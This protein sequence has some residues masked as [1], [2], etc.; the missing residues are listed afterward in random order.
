MAG[1]HATRSATAGGGFAFDNE[2]PRHR[3]YLR[4]F[5]LAGRA[6][7]QRR[8]ARLHRGR[9][10]SPRRA[11]AVRRLGGGA[12]R[13][14]D[15]AALLGARRRRHADDD[16]ARHA[17]A[18][19]RGAGLPRQLLRGRRLR[20]L[21]RQAA[22]DRGGVGGGRRAHLP[23]SRQHARQ[24]RAPATAGA[25]R[26]GDDGARPGRCSA[27]SGNGRPAP[28]SPTPATSRAAGAVGEYNGKFMCNQM[29][30]R[31]GSCVTPDGTCP[32]HLPQL[33]LSAASAGSLPGCAWRRTPDHGR[34]C[35][36]AGRR[37][38]RMRCEEFRA[39]VLAGLAAPQKE[40][41]TKF[42]YDAEGSRLFD[43]I[44]ELD[45]YYPT[46]TE[47]AILSADDRRHRRPLPP[48]PVLVEF[49]SGASLKVRLLLDALDRPAGYV[50]I[51]IS[52]DHLLWAAA[53]LAARLSRICRSCRC[54]PTSPGRFR[55]PRHLPGRPRLGF[56]PGSTIGNFH[57][58]EA[59]RILA[60]FARQ[61]GRGRLAA[62]R[63][64][65]EEGPG[66]PARRLQRRGRRHRRLQPQS[67]DTHQPRAGRHLR[68]R[69]VSPRA[70]STTPRPG[71]SRCT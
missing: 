63:R 3:I 52:R 53:A 4:P 10:L 58:A 11:L 69:R 32:G 31:G 5:R 35:R 64:R 70:R 13:G 50:P 20:P 12:G 37:A 1:G 46:R 54:A 16:A 30:L 36:G 27:T 21:G 51:D 25:G 62:D 57:P 41:P 65:P 19:A 22:A 44:C 14:L 23:V 7:H 66:H 29:V 42:F 61:L 15:G 45:E 28:T 43:R 24:R 47:M 9:R 71:G 6:R 8:V 49:G 68:S 67:A 17:A 55:L 39:A 33:L 59:T 60:G 26:R 40:I 2:G 56:F 48:R 38:R 34:L 18:R